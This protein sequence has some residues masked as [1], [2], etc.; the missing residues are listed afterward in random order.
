MNL[1]RSLYGDIHIKPQEPVYMWSRLSCGLADLKAG[2]ALYGGHWSEVQCLVTAFAEEAGLD[3]AV[4][5]DRWELQLPHGISTS[6]GVTM[7][8]GIV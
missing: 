6:A 1:I 3:L 8:E 5:D 4:K 2:C 7:P